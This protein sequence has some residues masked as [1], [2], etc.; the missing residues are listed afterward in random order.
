MEC[1]IGPN[2]PMDGSSDIVF[3]SLGALRQRVEEE[4]QQEKIV[5]YLKRIELELKTWQQ[6]MTKLFAERDAKIDP[7]KR[8]A[9]V[10]KKEIEREM[11]AEITKIHKEFEQDITEGSKNVQRL[12]KERAAIIMK[13]LSEPEKLV[14]EGWEGTMVRNLFSLSTEQIEF[15]VWKRTGKKDS[16]CHY[17][18]YGN[19]E[20]RQRSLSQRRNAGIQ[21]LKRNS[22]RF[23]HNIFHEICECPTLKAIQCENCK[24][25][26]HTTKRC[27]SN[28]G[29]GKSKKKDRIK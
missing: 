10:K 3:V 8:S 15:L 21:Y 26:G 28:K 22:C 5:N 11:N 7:V 14:W 12:K 18:T 27:T 24:K 25:C 19:T 29:T 2:G 17:Q 4:T 1:I 20:P 6:K 13:T 9:D 16:F 23:C